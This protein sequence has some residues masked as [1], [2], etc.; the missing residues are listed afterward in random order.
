MPNKPNRRA[1]VYI[2]TLKNPI[3]IP[4]EPLTKRL[5]IN[6]KIAITKLIEILFPWLSFI[7]NKYVIAS[8][9]SPIISPA[10]YI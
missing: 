7:G 2:P 6:M 9:T 3:A 8:I 4:V 1:V 10:K 5:T